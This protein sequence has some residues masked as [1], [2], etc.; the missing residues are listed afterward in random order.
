MDDVG[1]GTP[2]GGF[3]GEEQDRDQGVAGVAP[4]KDPPLPERVLLR[5]DRE[6]FVLGDVCPHVPPQAADATW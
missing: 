6:A 5:R 2:R 3:T 4:Q 1:H